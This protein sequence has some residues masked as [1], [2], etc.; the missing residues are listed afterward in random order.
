M[1]GEYIGRD[2][3]GQ[4]LAARRFC[5]ELATATAGP[6]IAPGQTVRLRTR[7]PGSARALAGTASI[8]ITLAALNGRPSRLR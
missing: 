2:A 6:T 8:F 7:H 1:P 5:G 3:N 4:A